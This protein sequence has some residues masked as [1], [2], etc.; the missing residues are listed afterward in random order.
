MRPS[1]VEPSNIPADSRVLPLGDP[2]APGGRAGASANELSRP[3]PALP[4]LESSARLFRMREKP[5]RFGRCRQL[6]E[7]GTDCRPS[8]MRPCPA[9]REWRD[10]TAGDWPVLRFCATRPD[11]FRTLQ[12]TAM[13]AGSRNTR[14]GLNLQPKSRGIVAVQFRPDS[15]KPSLSLEI[16]QTKKKH[17]ASGA[18]PRPTLRCLSREHHPYQRPKG[19]D[20][21]Q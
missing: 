5:G 1:G 11:R 20:N 8:G 7:W 19:A 21:R 3:F 10:V 6:D 14:I 4:T 15:N 16:R 2:A 12:S 9:S 17:E 13:I 18:P